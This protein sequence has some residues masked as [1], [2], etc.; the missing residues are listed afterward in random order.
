M[1]QEGYLSQSEDTYSVLRMGP[2]MQK[3]RDPDTHVIV[4]MYIEKEP[5]RGRKKASKARS[6]DALT[7]AG[8]ELFERLRTLRLRIAREESLPPY[9]IFSDKSLIDMCVKVPHTKAEMLN[10]NGVGE[11]KYEKYGQLFLEEIKGFEEEHPG[12]VI[13]ERGDEEEQEEHKDAVPQKDKK[14]LGSAGAAWSDEEDELLVREYQGGMK[15]SEMAK[16]H[17]RTSGAI[18]ARL[19]KQGLVE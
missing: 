19:K 7:T 17:Q 3:L 13:S 16:S 1:L 18:R 2:E 14:V 5:E 15:I 6:T 8:F 12:V 10:V 4:R 9:I 11:N